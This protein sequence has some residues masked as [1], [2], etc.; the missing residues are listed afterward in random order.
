MLRALGAWKTSSERILVRTVQPDLSKDN[1]SLPKSYYIRCMGLSSARGEVHLTGL[2]F[3]ARSHG[4]ESGREEKSRGTERRIFG[5][6]EIAPVVKPAQSC[7]Q[8]SS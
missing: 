2:G 4:S 6:S 7:K 8:L 5:V 1:R 3:F